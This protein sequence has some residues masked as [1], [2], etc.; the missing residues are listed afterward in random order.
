[1]RVLHVNSYYR[2]GVFYKHLFDKLVE[3]GID[4]SVY[5]PISQNPDSL[6]MDYGEYTRIVKTNGKY[7]RYFFLLKQHK[8]INN[9]SK[10]YS[11]TDFNILHAHSLFTNGHIA[12]KLNAEYGVPYIVSVRNTDVNLF[13]KHMIHLRG[14]GVNIMLNAETVIF[15]SPSYRDFVIERYIPPKNRAEILSKSIIIPNGIDEFWLHNLNKKTR[16]KDERNLNLITVGGINNNK[17]QLTVAKAAELL[18][19]SGYKVVYTIVGNIEDKVVYRKLMKYSFIR[20]IDNCSKEELINYYRQADIFIMPSIAETFGLVYAEAM[21][22]GLPI[23]YSAGQ[24]FDGQFS[25]GEVGY[26]VDCLNKDDVVMKLNAIIIN[27]TEI[28][29]RCTFYC[30]KFDWVNITKEYV[31][32]YENICRRKA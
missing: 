15:I 13:L 3:Q 7:D 27:Y 17:N 12:S 16:S 26:A 18:C 31:D 10:E 4:I 24:G 19:R 25:E 22:Q 14:I 11:I 20:H 1:M 32:L 8:I 21:S 2:K 6:Y 5:I 9:I 28:S 29:N 30:M 23:I